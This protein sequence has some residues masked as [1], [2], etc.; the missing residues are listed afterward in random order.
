MSHVLLLAASLGQGH[1]VILAPRHS[2]K[3]H[4]G[5]VPVMLRSGQGMNSYETRPITIR[6]GKVRYLVQY[7]DGRFAHFVIGLAVWM[8]RTTSTL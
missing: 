4:M 3:L 8:S 5:A 1:R 7:L 6:G 2:A